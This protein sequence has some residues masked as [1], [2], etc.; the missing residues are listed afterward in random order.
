MSAE[1]FLSKLVCIGYP[2]ANLQGNS[3][4]YLFHYQNILPFLD[5]I[6]KY[7]DTSNILD[8]QEILEYE[9]LVSS[10]VPIL[11]GEALDEALG[12]FP[13]LKEVNVTADDLRTEINKLRDELDDAKAKLDFYTSKKDKFSAEHHDL[14]KQHTEVLSLTAKELSKQE[15]AV[16]DCIANGAELDAVLQDLD[17]GAKR[18]SPAFS[19]FSSSGDEG[20]GEFFSVSKIRDFQ[21]VEMK[22]NQ[23]IK[24]YIQKQFFEDILNI[25]GHCTNDVDFLSFQADDFGP[26]CVKGPDVEEYRSNCME[27]TRLHSAHLT[28]E[29]QLLDARLWESQAAAQLTK[30]NDFLKNIRISSSCMSPSIFGV[31]QEETEGKHAALQAQVSHLRNKVIPQLLKE[32]VD[33]R[34]NRALMTDYSL[35]LVRQ[36]YFFTKADKVLSCLIAQRARTEFV[37]SFLE[38][39]LEN[40]AETQKLIQTTLECVSQEDRRSTQSLKLMKDLN[41]AVPANYVIPIRDVNCHTLYYLLVDSE[42]ESVPK[43]QALLAGTTSFCEEKLR[44]E[45]LMKCRHEKHWGWIYS[46]EQMHSSLESAVLSEASYGVDAISGHQ[47]KRSMWQMLPLVG[48][49]PIV[50]T[51]NQVKIN[52]EQLEAKLKSVMK[53]FKDKQKALVDRP[54]LKQARRL[55]IRFY[56]TNTVVKSKSSRTTPC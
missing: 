11:K 48:L 22:Y 34:S 9:S 51:L 19:N 7:I 31:I 25:S 41:S 21:L 16:N 14:C 39:E 46:L 17:L 8:P 29:L 30:I 37:V 49:S 15:E 28:S 38:K 56:G 27:L 12:N 32:C 6:C 42:R 3:F 2:V 35:K 36:N 23:Q 40:H 55:F 1:E 54:S 24:E 47:P 20:R 4:D 13:Q 43:Y 5:W 50:R 53:Y 10:G 44:L 18:L 26:R 52:A 33:A 45:D